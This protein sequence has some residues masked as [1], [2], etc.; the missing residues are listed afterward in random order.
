M[1]TISVP[2]QYFLD[3]T[4]E[5]TWGPLRLEMINTIDGSGI[6]R[7]IVVALANTILRYTSKGYCRIL[8]AACSG[9]CVG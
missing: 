2:N 4:I 7:E 6:L 8:N 5:F 9:Q 3:E 1:H